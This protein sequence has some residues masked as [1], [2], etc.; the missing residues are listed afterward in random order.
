MNEC[1]PSHTP[2]TPSHIP[3]PSHPP[4]TSPPP[5]SPQGLQEPGT[6][7]SAL[8]QLLLDRHVALP[9]DVEAHM[10]LAANHCFRD[11]T[12]FDGGEVLLDLTVERVRWYAAERA[13]GPLI[14]IVTGGL[15][16]GVGW[17]R[18]VVGVVGGGV[19]VGDV[20]GCFVL[21]VSNTPTHLPHPPPRFPTLPIHITIHKSQSRVWCII[22][23]KSST[24]SIG[25]MWACGSTAHT[26]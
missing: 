12:W 13:S 15:V 8:L 1:K 6:L 25:G 4:L 23:S 5:Q 14:K 22:S 19:T 10:L 17:W 18:V 2:C 20:V 7:G 9:F 3:T 11:A 24:G 16:V 26:F 21:C